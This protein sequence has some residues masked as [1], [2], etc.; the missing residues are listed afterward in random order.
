MEPTTP[1]KRV[2]LYCRVSTDMQATEGHSLGT[3]EELCRE[4]CNKEF[5]PEGYEAKVYVE[6]GQ[7]GANTIRQFANDGEKVRSVLSDLCD[8]AEQGDITHVVTYEVSRMAR[9]DFLWKLIRHT[10]LEPSDVSLRI[11]SGNLNLDNE[12]DAFMADMLSLSLV[13]SRERALIRRRILDAQESR[14]K[15]G[16]WP[17]GHPPWG[18]RWQTDEEV[19]EGERNTIVPDMERIMWVNF[20]VDR[21]LRLGWSCRR[22]AE[23]MQ[24]TGIKSGRTRRRWTTQSVY[25]IVKHFGHAGLVKQKD[26]SFI[27][28]V[29]YKHRIIEPETHYRILDTLSDRWSDD[30]RSYASENFPLSGIIRCGHCGRRLAVHRGGTA[31]ERFYRCP[32]SEAGE[33]RTCPGVMK[34]A[35]AIEQH[36]YHAVGDF[37]SSAEMTRLVGEEAEKILATRKEDLTEQIEKIDQSLEELDEKLHDWAEAFTDGK[38]S[39]KQFNTVSNTWQEEYDDLEQEREKLKR[40]MHHQEVDRNAMQR[41]KSALE[42]F[43]DT[44]PELSVDRQREILSDLLETLTLGCADNGVELK[45]KIKFLPE[46]TRTIPVHGKRPDEGLGSLTDRELAV[47]KHIDD[48][49]SQTEINETIGIRSTNTILWR[50][51]EKTGYDDNQKL[52]AAARPLIE[53]A[54]PRLPLEARMREPRDTPFLTELQEKHIRLRAQGLKYREI[55]EKLDRKMGTVGAMMTTIRKRIGAD[56]VDEAIEIW[57]EKRGEQGSS[58]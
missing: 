37:A 18:W 36:V 39:E 20:M 32:Q 11:V 23:A 15:A 50:A 24:E 22:V 3:Q 10:I 52:A 47:L 38:M 34:K 40:R 29:H 2:A 33:E 58:R 55:A 57:K 44:L 25:R 35:E 21:I 6:S 19:A 28:G 16:Y 27:E 53:E 8:D 49:L 17:Q 56:T 1:T 54:L 31:D 7:S 41:V 26:G 43:E 5:G 51:R 45:I 48:G 12:D 4:Y 46:I 13:S 9:E 14:R 42:T 30:E